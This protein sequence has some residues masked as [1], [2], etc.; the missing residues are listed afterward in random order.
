MFK[1]ENYYQRCPDCYGSCLSDGE[2]CE[3][4]LG[5]GEDITDAG[6]ALIEFLRDHYHLTPKREKAD[7]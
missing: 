5:V 4:C 2:V 6:R 3:T 1:K 7:A